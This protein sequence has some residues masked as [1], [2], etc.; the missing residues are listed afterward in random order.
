MAGNR[1][2]PQEGFCQKKYKSSIVERNNT[3]NA[4]D[5]MFSI[6]F[7]MALRRL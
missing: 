4:T 7:S 2:E 6:L 1:K 3:T 5:L